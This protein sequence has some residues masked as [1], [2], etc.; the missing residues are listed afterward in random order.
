MIPFKDAIQGALRGW[1]DTLLAEASCVRKAS[2]AGLRPIPLR[3]VRDNLEP[4]T[5]PPGRGTA[6][7][8][9]GRNS[10]PERQVVLP[11]AQPEHRPPERHVVDDYALAAAW[12]VQSQEA[13]ERWPSLK[14]QARKHLE[15]QGATIISD[16]DDVM[17]VEYTPADVEH[18][19][20]ALVDEG[21]LMMDNWAAGWVRDDEP[22]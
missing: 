15:D 6:C 13:A 12:Y 1:I 11:E 9:Y 19:H 4:P 10:R 5:G 7:W 3:Y 14:A 17:V 20:A 8:C 16:V 18:S 22:R 21:K 2:R